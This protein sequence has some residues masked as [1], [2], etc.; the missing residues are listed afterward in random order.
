MLLNSYLFF[1]PILPARTKFGI[2]LCAVM[3][4]TVDNQIS[5]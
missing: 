3:R 1:V 2:L 5:A 4:Q